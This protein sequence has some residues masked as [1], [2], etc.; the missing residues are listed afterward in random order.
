M[1]LNPPKLSKLRKLH[2]EKLTRKIR[3]ISRLHLL[4]HNFLQDSGE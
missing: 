1:L 3:K 4:G 2:E